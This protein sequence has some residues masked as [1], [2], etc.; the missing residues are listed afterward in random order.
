MV[1]KCIEFVNKFSNGIQKLLSYSSRAKNE[2]QQLLDSINSKVEGKKTDEGIEGLKAALREVSSQA[3]QYRNACLQAARKGSDRQEIATINEALKTSDIDPLFKLV[4]EMLQLFSKCSQCQNSFEHVC[5]STRQKLR[6]AVDK[7][8]DIKGKVKV[9]GVVGG[10]AS[11]AGATAGVAALIG[12]AI[13]TPF[14]PPAGLIIAG[15]GGVATAA[16]VAGAAGTAITVAVA[17]EIVNDALREFESLSNDME[18]VK[19]SI[20]DI[21]TTMEECE[22]KIKS[23][24]ESGERA[25]SKSRV[26]K[27]ICKNINISLDGMC[28][29]FEQLIQRKL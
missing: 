26:S 16:G 15:I 14:F 7:Y 20:D 4:K 23:A 29:K 1:K 2:L 28:T 25:K 8:E 9:G 24:S 19:R 12:G 27:A 18:S 22:D 5:N 11:G 13:L 3:Q 10:V 6:S 21:N 17:I